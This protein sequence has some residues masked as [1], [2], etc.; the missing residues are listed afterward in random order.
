MRRGA[1]LKTG[2]GSQW[3]P[4]GSGDWYYFPP[5]AACTERK[6]VIRF[7]QLALLLVLLLAVAFVAWPMFVYLTNW[8]F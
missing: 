5:P 1:A 8:R 7:I 2:G 4:T 6:A 3:S